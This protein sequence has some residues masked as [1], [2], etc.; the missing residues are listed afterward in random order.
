LKL[1]AHEAREQG[2]PLS[3]GVLPAHLRMIEALTNTMR[4]RGHIVPGRATTH[5]VARNPEFVRKADKLDEFLRRQHPEARV[6]RALLHMGVEMLLDYLAGLPGA[7]PT[8]W[9]YVANNIHM[10]P[11]LFDQ[12][13]PGYAQARMLSVIITKEAPPHQMEPAA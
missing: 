3:S 4:N 13:F 8:S 5:G 9:N 11:A 12:S 2:T 6:R 10:I 1:G 7:L